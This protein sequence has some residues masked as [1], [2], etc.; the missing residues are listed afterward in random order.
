MGN[1]SGKVPPSDSQPHAATGVAPRWAVAVATGFG[2]GYLPIMPGT[3]GSAEG[4]AL[5]VVL[6]RLFGGTAHAAWYLLAAA[7]LLTIFSYWTIALALPHFSSD[8]PSAVVVDEIA[9]QAITLLALAFLNRDPVSSWFAVATGFLF[10]RI[11]DSLKPYPIWKMGY[12]EGA[13]GVLADDVGAA[14][15][16][17]LALYG[18]GRLGWV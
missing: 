4:A 14:I 11:L 10:F 18:L 15:V 1:P 16:A 17:A 2:A 7:A 5:Y 6:A 8:D 3:Y 13:L 9:G 12:W